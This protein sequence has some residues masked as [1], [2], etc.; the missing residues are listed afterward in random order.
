[1]PVDQ[2][3]GSEGAVIAMRPAGYKGGTRDIRPPSLRGRRPERVADQPS[4]DGQPPARIS[5]VPCVMYQRDWS[6]PISAASW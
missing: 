6:N 4:P 2:P 5:V 1:M 3:G